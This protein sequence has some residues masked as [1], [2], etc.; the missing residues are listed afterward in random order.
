MPEH[1]NHYIFD[2]KTLEM[3]IAS[4]M[5]HDARQ[6]SYDPQAS[7]PIIPKTGNIVAIHVNGSLTFRVG[8]HQA[9]TLLDVINSSSDEGRKVKKVLEQHHPGRLDKIL[10]LIN[11]ELTVFQIRRECSVS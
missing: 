9:A 8:P 5:D 7:I 1:S 11:A 4:V 6:G 3:R 10:T 2:P